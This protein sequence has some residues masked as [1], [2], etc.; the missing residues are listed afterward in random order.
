VTL[1]SSGFSPLASSEVVVATGAFLFET[2]VSFGDEHA[3]III[4]LKK[5]N[6]IFFNLI[7]F[8]P[9]NTCLGVFLCNEYAR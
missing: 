1:S 7:A 4:T 6:N 5:T 9:H 2:A 3:V 8:I